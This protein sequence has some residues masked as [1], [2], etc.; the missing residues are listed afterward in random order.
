MCEILSTTESY[1]SKASFFVVVIQILHAINRILRIAIGA[2]KLEFFFIF[3]RIF[4]ISCVGT[5]TYFL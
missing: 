5:P 3:W 4:C 1:F 2:K